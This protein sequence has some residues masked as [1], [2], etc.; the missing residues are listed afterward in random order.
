MIFVQARGPSVVK[1]VSLLDPKRQQ[2]AGIALARLRMNPEAIVEAILS[3][4]AVIL[5]PDKV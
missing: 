2:N 1:K 3:C 5:T 4:N